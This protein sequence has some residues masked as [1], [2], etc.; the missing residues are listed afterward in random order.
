MKF[1][2][3]ACDPMPF[4]KYKGELMQDVPAAYLHWLWTQ[5]QEGSSGDPK[6]MDYIKRNLHALKKE[7]PDGI[8]S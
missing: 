2:L 1:E 7:Y 6:V 4:G 5:N 3:D 8:W